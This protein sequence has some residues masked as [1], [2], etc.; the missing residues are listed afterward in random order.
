MIRLERLNGD[1]LYLNAELIEKIEERPDTIV[2][3]ATGNRLIVNN[4]G[5]EVLNKIMLYRQRA[6]G[7][8]RI[9]IPSKTP[10][11]SRGY[12]EPSLR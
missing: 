4:K 1:P 3:L 10:R 7:T 8:R 2:T 5:T 6:Y 11:K 9:S 12:P